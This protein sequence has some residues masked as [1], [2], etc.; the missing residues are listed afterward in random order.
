[1]ADIRQGRTDSPALPPSPTLRM[2][3][4][5]GKYSVTA[6][7]EPSGSLI[8]R[9]APALPIRAKYSNLCAPRKVYRPRT[10]RLR[11]QPLT[12]QDRMEIVEDAKTRA[13]ERSLLSRLTI[14]KRRLIDR[15]TD[16]PPTL[17]TAEP[18]PRHEYQPPAPI[19]SDI[20][21]RKTKIQLRIEEFKPMI[22]ATLDRLDPLFLKLDR[23]DG[24]EDKGLRL[25]ITEDD[26][27]ELWYWY[28]NLQ[29]L[30]NEID[31]KG[32]RFTA[33]H[34]R[35]L[36]GVLKRIG[37]VSF[38]DLS[39]RWVDICKELVEMKIRLP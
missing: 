2:P 35:Q 20:H 28:C 18:S 30:Y 6:K 32:H 27:K 29:D 4:V 5:L 21:F 9:I 12:L 15:I 7:N 36:A 31:E 37:K 26:R 8:E 16:P 17:D 13:S 39:D 33:K 11:T 22:R 25:R 24:L 3:K 38:N 14:E 1:M 34:W 19:P 10:T 23:V